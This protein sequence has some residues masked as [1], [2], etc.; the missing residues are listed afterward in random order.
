MLPHDLCS[1]VQNAARARHARVAVAHT[2]QNLGILNILLRAGLVSNV[3]RGDTR[4]PVP[5][6]FDK[7]PVAEQRIW[8]ELKYRND[9]PVLENMHLVS[10]PSKRVVM[11]VQ[12]IRRICS[13]R[14]AKTVRPLGLGEVA[15]VKTKNK[16]HEWVE[17]REAVRLKLDGE[18]ICRAS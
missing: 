4:S 8:A 16:E 10:K 18:V 12:E 17:A 2:T 9:R 6:A 3:I 11:G 7:A 1:M 5:K 15:V 14:R 13:G